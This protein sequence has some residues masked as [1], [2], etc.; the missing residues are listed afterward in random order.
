MSTEFSEL[1]ISAASAVGTLGAVGAAFHLSGKTDAIRKKDEERL[2]RIHSLNLLPV[3]ETIHSDL[4]ASFAYVIFT[5]APPRSM[6]DVSERLKRAVKWSQDFEEL[7]SIESLTAASLLK[8]PEIPS[9]RISYALGLLRALRLDISR[10]NAEHWADPAPASAHK[11]REWALAQSTA[12]DY[13]GV[14]LFSLRQVAMQQ[15]IIPSGEEIHGAPD[16]D[17]DHLEVPNLRHSLKSVVARFLRGF[18]AG[19][20]SQ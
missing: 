19:A 17:V 9:L 5:D 7:S 4:R 12:S 18:R 15:S 20:G 3:L 10:F 8:L 6:D 14:A 11:T 1:L 16:D 13:I 2:Q